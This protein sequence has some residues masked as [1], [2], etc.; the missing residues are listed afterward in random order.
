MPQHRHINDFRGN[1]IDGVARIGPRVTAEELERIISVAPEG[2]TVRLTE[3]EFIFNDS[4]TVNRSDVALSGAG[5]GKTQITFSEAAL[6]NDPLHGIFFKGGG[7]TSVGH[8]LANAAEGSRTLA[9]GSGHRLSVGDTVRIF[10]DNDPEYLAQLGGSTWVG[11]QNSALRTSMAKVVSVEGDTIT[12][13][14]GVHFDFAADA[15]QVQRINTLEN[16]A[17]EGMTIGYQLGTPDPGAFTNVLPS[18]ERY[19]AVDFD[20]TFQS[21]IEDVQVINGPSQAFEINRSLDITADGLQAHGAFNKG[22]G[23]NG[24]AY[25]LR[26]SYD[27]NFTHLEDTGMRHSVLFASW[28]SSVGND[29]QVDF[30][31]RDINFHGGPDHGNTVRVDQSIRDPAVDAM[32]TTLWIN[33]GGETFGAPTDPQANEAVFEYVIGSRRND[34][35]QGTNDGVYLD[36]ALGHDTLTGG[37]GNDLLQG[38]RGN[39]ILEGQEGSDTAF[40]TSAFGYY[41]ISRLSDGRLFL[42]GNSDDEILDGVERAIFADGTQYNVQTGSV[43]QGA[44]PQVPSPDAIVNDNAMASIQAYE[45]EV[46]SPAAVGLPMG[47]IS[48][49]SFPNELH[50]DSPQAISESGKNES[51]LSTQTQVSGNLTSVWEGGYTAEVFVTNTSSMA[52][53]DPS[54]IF[55]LPGEIHTLWNGTLTRDDGRYRISDD[56]SVTLQPGESWRF[57]YKVYDNSQ[58]LPANTSVIGEVEPPVNEPVDIASNI[59]ELSAAGYTTEVMV[60]NT[61]PTAI[62]DPSVSFDLP[63]DIH[64]LSDGTL[65]RDGGRYTISDDSGTALQ[66]GDIWRFTYLVSGSQQV[67]PENAVVQGQAEPAKTEPG[68]LIDVDGNSLSGDAGSIMTGTG[69]GETLNGLRG[70]DYLTGAGGADRLIG[71]QGA[72]LLAG[73]DGADTFIYFSALESVPSNND[74]L[75]DFSRLEGDRIDLSAVDANTNMDGHQDFTWLDNDTEFSGQ[76]GELRASGNFLQ[77]EV[78]GDAAPDMEIEVLGVASPVQNDVIT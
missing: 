13:D 56:N 74:T 45:G 62:A 50:T 46:A 43:S 39:D 15:A 60:E 24:Y 23:G 53:V 44:I 28:R 75:L 37:I 59:T 12:L 2:G 16:V 78:N 77:A 71:G 34:V 22:S 51:E 17:L 3:G 73:G 64:T 67:L 57:E 31:D 69:N 21:R 5:A 76:G 49:L 70:D 66:P 8:L 65:E 32:S 40:F 47:N 1:F 29:I 54:L 58:T 6:A 14:R 63:A 41:Q 11:D 18:L 33:Q 36:G 61:S 30:T 20:R 25:E 19:R 4:I 9:L 68:Q 10:Q 7:T 35:V 55:D 26:E 42:D 72:D 48:T 38:G 52:I 27:G